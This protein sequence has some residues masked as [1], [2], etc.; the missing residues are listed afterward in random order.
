MQDDDVDIYWSTPT[1]DAP[2]MNIDGKPWPTNEGGTYSNRTVTVQ[3]GL[4]NSLNTISAR[5]LDKIGTTYSYDFFK[6]KFHISTLTPQDCDLAPMAT[7]ALT[8][9]VTVL[10]MTAAYQAF[11]NGGYYYEPYGY[12]KI[13]DSKGNVII[14]KHLIKIKRLHLAKTHHG[15]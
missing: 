10:E 14:E 3:Y 2:L 13:E 1:K 12:Y 7:G 8:Y 5:T 9:G 11:G 6:N 15:L 4:A